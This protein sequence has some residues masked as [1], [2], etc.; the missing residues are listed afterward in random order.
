MVTFITIVLAI[1]LVIPLVIA[2][3]TGIVY[4]GK[5][6]HK[7]G[8]LQLLHRV[9]SVIFDLLIAVIVGAFVG[10]LFVKVFTL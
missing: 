7:T 3:G 9:L 10:T 4:T 2:L 8:I 5:M 6:I 1:Q